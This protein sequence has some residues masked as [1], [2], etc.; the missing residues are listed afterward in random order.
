MTQRFNLCVPPP[1][2]NCR[3]QGTVTM[4]HT[5]KGSTVNVT[6]RCEHCSHDWT[7]AEHD[8]TTAE[9]RA[10]TGER[11]KITRSDRRDAKR[12]G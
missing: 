5:I 4:E 9:R 2:P 12:R 7:V 1:C 11:R 10:A 3:S 8:G 6:W